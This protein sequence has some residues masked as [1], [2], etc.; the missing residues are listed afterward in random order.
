[1]TFTT[2]GPLVGNWDRGGLEQLLSNLI[3][4]ALKYGEGKPVDVIIESDAHFARVVVKDRG[5]G[6]SAEDQARIFDRF[7]RAGSV[8]HY[9]GF[10]LGLWISRRVVQALGG[11]IRVESAP[12]Q[13]S[14]FT[15]ELPR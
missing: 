9:G 3:S 12:G 6:I 14:T 1:M 7:E 15:V 4:N 11:A 5:I 13:G 8:R 10:G 2:A